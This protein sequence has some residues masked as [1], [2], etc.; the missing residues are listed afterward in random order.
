[1]LDLVVD[2]LAAALAAAPDSVLPASSIGPRRPASS[3]E[4]PTLALGVTVE[5]TRGTGLGRYV[6]T[7]GTADDPQPI[8]GDMYTG[9]LT[10]EIWGGSSSQTNDVFRRL[11]QR[12]TDGRVALREQGF[13]RIE[14]ASLAPLENVL[15]SAPTGSP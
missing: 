3:A 9:V 6:G 15:Q 12:L 11:H 14:S 13:M 4:L 5:A 7:R 2:R 1:M 10:I 8:L